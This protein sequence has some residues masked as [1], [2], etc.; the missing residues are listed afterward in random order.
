[1][2]VPDVDATEVP[3]VNGKCVPVAAAIVAVF[4]P[5]TRGTATVT[6]P[7]VS[8]VRTKE[9]II[10]T[11][12]YRITQREPDWTVTANPELIVIGPAE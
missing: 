4:E 7:D 9:P 12:Y 1:M 10:Y 6:E 5:A 8:P 2:L 3:D 11:S